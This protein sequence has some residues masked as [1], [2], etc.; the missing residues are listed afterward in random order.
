[1]P[2]SATV[3]PA[4][5]SCPAPLRGHDRIVIGH[6]GGGALSAEL[7]EHLFLPAFGAAARNATP[8]DAAVLDLPGGRLAFSTDTYVVRPLFF[9]GGS[10]GELAVNGTVNDLAMLGA[11]PHALSVGFVLEEG[12][13][14][15]VLGRVA[16]AVGAAASRAGVELVT[17]DT[18]VVER[19][20]GDG[21]YLNTAGVGLIPEGVDLRPERAVPG[22]VVLVSG[23]VGRHGIA[24]LSVREGLEFGTDLRSDCAPLHGLVET[25]VAAVADPLDIHVLRDATRGGLAA[26]VCELAGAARVTIALDERAIPVGDEVRAACGF[27]G[28]DPLQVAN[29]GTLVAIVAPDVADDVLTAMRG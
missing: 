27:L 19:G 13:E 24:V 12:L 14:L 23:P 29:E 17:G 3:D 6:G 20:H 25:V 18:K 9:P 26:A 28:L 7:V 10:I 2:G 1:M 4:V 11:R 22:D 8:T 15:E 16:T 5:W 21:I